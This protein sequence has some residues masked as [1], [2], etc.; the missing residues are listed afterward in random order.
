[1]PQSV[2]HFE[3]QITQTVH[4]DYLLYLPPDYDPTSGQRWPLILF[5]HA[6]GER[7]SDLE[8]V[9]LYGIPFHLEQGQDLPFIIVSP[10]CPA[11]SYWTLHIQEL[12]ALLDDIVARYPVDQGR[13]YMTGMSMGGAGTWLLAAFTPERFA[14][15][16]PVCSH[17]VPIP[18]PRL[19]DI[20]IWAFHGD[21]D[22]RAPVTDIAMTVDRLQALSANAKLTIYPGVGHNAWDPA[23]A[24]PELYQWFLGHSRS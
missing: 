24:D 5:L 13:I 21:A 12:T 11:G 19:K 9:K 3:K 1:M 14:A 4:L 7:G 22:E 16:A 17:M 20:P 18:L 15:I 6:S 10:Q 2:Q 8:L 23:Y